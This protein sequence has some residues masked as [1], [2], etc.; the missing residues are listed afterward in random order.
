[1]VNRL[2]GRSQNT[3]FHAARAGKHVYTITHVQYD[4][5]AARAVTSKFFGRSLIVLRIVFDGS[6]NCAL[7]QER[8][9]HSQNR[10]KKS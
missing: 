10:K 1:M 3:K 5:K 6:F 8:W 9:K 7:N 4:A 2:P